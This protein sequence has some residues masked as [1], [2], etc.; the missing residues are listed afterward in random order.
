[1]PERR[2][3]YLFGNIIQ[4]NESG[5]RS[6]IHR[7]LLLVIVKKTCSKFRCSFSFNKIMFPDDYGG[8]APVRFEMLRTSGFGFRGWNLRFMSWDKRVEV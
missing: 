2:S 5:P 1:M 4:F 3:P 6:S 8:V 7:G